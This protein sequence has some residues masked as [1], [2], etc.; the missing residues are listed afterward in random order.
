VKDEDEEQED[1]EVEQEVEKEL[2]TMRF[3]EGT[4]VVPQSP[5]TYKPRVPP[6]YTW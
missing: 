5:L 6:V 3:C 2:A 1:E 4:T